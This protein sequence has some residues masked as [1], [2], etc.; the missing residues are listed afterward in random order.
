[1]PAMRWLALVIF[2]CAACDGDA[3]SPRAE[4][5]R[6]TT[7]RAA[8]LAD[9]LEALPGI[10]HASVILYLPIADP[11]APP[12][13]ASIPTASVILELEPGADSDA[14][15]E[16][17]RAATVAAI[18]DAEVKVVTAGPLP[19]AA[20]A[21]SGTMRAALAAALAVIAAL[22]LWIVGLYRR[23]ARAQ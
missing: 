6:A 17:A 7:R 21:P 20:P 16:D 15:T 19:K 2:L 22:A 3:W 1:M 13:V 5:D 12:A 14:I 18:P 11:L 9:H 10:E 8:A 23:A 4:H